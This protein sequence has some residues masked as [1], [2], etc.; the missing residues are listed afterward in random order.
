MFIRSKAKTIKKK[1]DFSL[2]LRLRLNPRRLALLM[3]VVLIL[4]SSYGFRQWYWVVRN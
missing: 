1:L 4:A 3:F 2:E